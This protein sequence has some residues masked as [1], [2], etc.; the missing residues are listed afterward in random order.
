MLYNQ[1]GQGDFLAVQTERVPMDSLPKTKNRHAMTNAPLVSAY[2]T[3][4]GDRFTVFVLSRK[5][6]NFPYA[7]DDGVTP[8]TLNL[9]FSKVKKITLYKMDGAPRTNNLDAENVRIESREISAAAFSPQFA[10]DQVHGAD[11]GGLPPAA[12]YAYVFEGVEMATPPATHV[13]I[14][15]APDQPEVSPLPSAAFQI[16][17]DRPVKGF[18]AGIVKL[19][20]VAEAMAKEEVTP[21]PGGGGTVYRVE[22]ED[23]E[24]LGK[25][26][27]EIPASAL[28]NG[29]PAATVTGPEVT[30]AIV[31]PK[32]ELLAVESFDYQGGDLWK[33][34]GGTGWKG[35][36]KLDNFSKPEERS[37]T[38]HIGAAAPF[39]TTGMASTPSYLQAGEHYITAWRELAVDGAFDFF[40]TPREKGKTATVIGKKGTTLWISALVRMDRESDLSLEFHKDAFYQGKIGLAFS[41]GTFKDS[42]G[43]NQKFWGLHAGAES[44]SAEVHPSQKPVLPGEEVLLVMRVHFGLQQDAADLFINPNPKSGD[45]GKPAATVTSLEGRRFVFDKLVIRCADYEGASVDEIRFGDS[46]K[47]VVPARK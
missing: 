2:A 10:L 28:G 42:T 5:L 26:G 13:K 47:A 12:V 29:L 31:P 22:V 11:K 9:P 8:V 44:E 16:Y 1:H 24:K 36:W 3:R 45:P 39:G 37:A 40:A 19:T 4:K 20:G 34:A 41:A 6:D 7:N 35:P 14:L 17:F 23:V 32:D 27:V 43:G 21:I 33:N 38:Y 18:N 15:R 30:Y 25:F 46:F